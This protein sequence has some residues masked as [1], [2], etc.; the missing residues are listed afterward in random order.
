MET[1]INT[2]FIQTL[3][4]PK[5]QNLCITNIGSLYK[6]FIKQLIELCD[7]IFDYKA[8]FREI[9]LAIVQLK[10]ISSEL[11]DDAQSTQKYITAAIALLESEL[12]LLNE[13]INHPALFQPPASIRGYDIHLSKRYTKHDLIE[14]LSSVDCATVFVDSKGDTVP[15]SKL[16]ALFEE[17]LD[18]K[19][20]NPF[21]KR[22]KVLNRKVRTTKFLR[23]LQESLIERSQR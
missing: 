17:L 15:F 10:L 9:S 23:V 13:R 14:L 1:L 7:A 19:L 2:N 21:N 5:I 22:A 6:E 18:I 11:T 20:S 3:S 8:L 4:E 12:H 16:T